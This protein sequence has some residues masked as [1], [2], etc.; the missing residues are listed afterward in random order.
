[1]KR[2]TV[3]GI[4]ALW[5]TL[6][7]GCFGSSTARVRSYYS[8][9]YPIG[10][11]QRRYEQPRYP[12]HVRVGRVRTA[13]AYDRQELAYRTN[14]WQLHYYVYHLWVSRPSKMVRE[15]IAA[16][17]QAS[18]LVREVST[19]IEDR[20]PDYELQS[21]VVAI[22]ELDAAGGQWLAHLAMRFS[23]VRF[24][25]HV[26]VWEYSFDERR[27]VTVRQP[28]HVV[29]ALSAL[30]EEQF[31]EALDGLDAYFAK[32]TGAAP[33]PAAGRHAPPA[34]PHG[35]HKPAPPPRQPAA[36]AGP[37]VRLKHMP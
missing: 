20:L 24:A 15:L 16:H 6:L 11:Q 27:P 10:T 26:V 5:A 18:N 3:V 1:M 37:A 31:N 13:L 28:V 36:P 30:F 14:P 12:V 17:L 19:R 34:Q 29:E 33:P 9:A 32:A 8:L 21:E 7:S 35:E 23:L 2:R 25:D 4:V 22:E